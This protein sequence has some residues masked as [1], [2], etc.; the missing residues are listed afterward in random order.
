MNE[1]VETIRLRLDKKIVAA[2]ARVIFDDAYRSLRALDTESERFAHLMR[3]LHRLGQML[4]Q[5]RLTFKRAVKFS[6]RPDVKRVLADL[7]EEFKVDLEDFVEEP[8][9]GSKPNHG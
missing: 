5:E 6:R 1:Y 7:K 9:P 3:A 2:E 4:E 8:A